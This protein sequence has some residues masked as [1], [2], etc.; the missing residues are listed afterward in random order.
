MRVVIAY[1]L[2][3]YSYSC[4]NR[5]KTEPVGSKGSFQTSNTTEEFD[6][7]NKRFHND[8]VFQLSRIAFPIGGEYADGESRFKWT[9]HNWLLM[10]EPIGSALSS[11][12]YKHEVNRSDSLVTERIWIDSSGFN[13]ERHFKLIKGKWYLTY[14]DDWNI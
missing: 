1:I 11:N 10:R 6:L 4:T 12:E 3:L 2:L 9:R 13:I 7:F 14:Y 5:S 8:S